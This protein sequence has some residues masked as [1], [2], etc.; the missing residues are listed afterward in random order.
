MN[1][2]SSE[3]LGGDTVRNAGNYEKLR[4]N[5]RLIKEYLEYFIIGFY[6]KYEPLG[7]CERTQAYI[8]YMY[9]KWSEGG[10]SWASRY[11]IPL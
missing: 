7:G 4:L 6:E 11:R 2:Y 3:I 5:V 9:A 8:H 10:N 1:S